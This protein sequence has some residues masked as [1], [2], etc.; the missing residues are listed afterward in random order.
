M[1]R[2]NETKRTPVVE[3]SA[4]GKPLR[5]YHGL[6]DS[7]LPYLDTPAEPDD[8]PAAATRVRIA[9]VDNGYLLRIVFPPGCGITPKRLV[10]RSYKEVAELLDDAFL[11]PHRIASRCAPCSR[12]PG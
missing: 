2:N 11:S 3:T 6:K 5:P 1:E 4:S 12:P 10:A 8:R 9:R 7:P